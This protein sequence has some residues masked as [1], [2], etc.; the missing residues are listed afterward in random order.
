MQIIFTFCFF[1]ICDPKISSSYKSSKVFSYLVAAEKIEF[2]HNANKEELMEGIKNELL[3]DPEVKFGSNFEQQNGKNNQ[4]KTNQNQKQ[5]KESNSNANAKI[6]KNKHSKPK[7]QYTKNQNTWSDLKWIDPQFFKALAATACILSF[8]LFIFEGWYWRTYGTSFMEQKSISWLAPW[9][10]EHM[11]NMNHQHFCDGRVSERD[12]DGINDF[13]N[14]RHGNEK[15]PL[16]LND[17]SLA[18]QSSTKDE[19]DRPKSSLYGNSG[20]TSRSTSQPPSPYKS[21]YENNKKYENN[22]DHLN[23]Y[24][25]NNNNYNSNSNYTSSNYPNKESH[26]RYP[27]SIYDSLSSHTNRYF[28][29]TIHCKNYMRLLR[30]VEYRQFYLTNKVDPLTAYSRRLTDRDLAKN[31]SCKLDKERRCD[32]MMQRAWTMPNLEDKVRVAK[33]ALESCWEIY[34]ESVMKNDKNKDKDVNS[35]EREKILEKRENNQVMKPHEYRLVTPAYDCGLAC[36]L[37]AEEDSVTVQDSEAWFRR[38]LRS[39][40]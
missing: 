3:K 8:I 5:P 22:I 34:E 9:L 26:S 37:L 2:D 21:Y 27:N 33:M 6:P 17:L 23:F 1:D 16:F 24:D 4:K 29:H 7:F 19:R 28:G 32:E 20:D 38:A 30:G 18:H 31:F 15:E 12:K 13:S 14:A 10:Q 11:N 39:A 35:P 36:V 40:F 25:Q